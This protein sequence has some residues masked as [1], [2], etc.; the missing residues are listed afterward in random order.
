MSP[1]ELLAAVLGL[2]SVWLNVRED[3]RGWPTGA[4]MV[5]LYFF[6]FARVQLYAAAGLQVVYF[7]VQFYGWHEWLHGGDGH[8]RLAISRTPPGVGRLGLLVGAAGTWLLGSVLGRYTDEALPFWDSGIASFSL[9]AQWM[10]ARKYLENWLLWIAIDVIAI[11]VY[12][13]RHLQ[14]T[15]VLYLL[16][17]VLC[18]RGYLAWRAPLLAPPGNVV[19]EVPT[20]IL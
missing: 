2:V 7:V 4:V 13:A 11:G 12:W 14:A 15:S 17:L 10:L 3:A 16:L 20:A 9:V 8:G 18:V 6:V 19:P 5:A 1:M